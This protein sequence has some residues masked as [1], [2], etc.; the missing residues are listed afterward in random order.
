MTLT[1]RLTSA[2]F[3][4]TLATSVSASSTSWCTVSPAKSDKHTDRRQTNLCCDDL[5]RMHFDQN[6]QLCLHQRL[7]WEPTSSP[8]VD[9]PGLWCLQFHI[10]QIQRLM[11]A[12]DVMSHNKFHILRHLHS[13][14]HNMQEIIIIIIIT[15]NLYCA[16]KRPGQTQQ[17]T[18]AT[19]PMTRIFWHIFISRYCQIATIDDMNWILRNC[20]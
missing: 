1:I 19:W 9:V 8:F 5:L 2:I 17:C 3:S 4:A 6:M 12:H 13:N 10:H 7:F 14:V 11:M 15:R 18:T 20:S 16:T